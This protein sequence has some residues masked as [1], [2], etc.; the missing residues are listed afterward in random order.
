VFDNVTIVDATQRKPPS[1]AAKK[2]Q[3]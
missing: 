3:W 1:E 2:E